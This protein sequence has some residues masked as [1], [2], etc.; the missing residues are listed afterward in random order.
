MVAY[1]VFVGFPDQVAEIA[2]DPSRPSASSFLLPLCELPLR[3]REPGP[4][5]AEFDALAC[6][7]PRKPAAA[8]HVLFRAAR[9]VHRAVAVILA[10][11]RFHLLGVSLRALALPACEPPVVVALALVASDI[12]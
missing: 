5:V 2:V 12:R 9:L 7:V 10:V 6:A 1:A 8:V 4:R 3:V 11:A